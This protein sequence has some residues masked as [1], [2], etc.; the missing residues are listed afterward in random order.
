[1]D[2]TQKSIHLKTID[3]NEDF[4]SVYYDNEIDNDVEYEIIRSQKSLKK[5]ASSTINNDSVTED[6]KSPMETVKHGMDTRKR[7]PPPNAEAVARMF[8]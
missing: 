4:E 6:R 7:P 8:N 3:V 2:V 5:I 1:M